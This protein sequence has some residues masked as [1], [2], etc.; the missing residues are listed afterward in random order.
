MVWKKGFNFRATAGLVTDGPDETYVVADNYPTTRNGVTF[1]WTGGAVLPVNRSTNPDRRLAGFNYHIITNVR[2]FKVD[3]PGNGTYD[4]RLAT[5]DYLA[6]QP[7]HLWE[8]RDD[9][10][11]LTSKADSGTLGGHFNDALGVD[12]G[13][14]DWPGSNSPFRGNFATSIFNLRIN[15]A[16]GTSGVTPIAHIMVK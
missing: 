6:P 13:Y 7:N 15:H 2:Y 1:G 10:T 9:T 3:L 12:Y 5:G 8:I 4:I 14:L 16:A 11:V